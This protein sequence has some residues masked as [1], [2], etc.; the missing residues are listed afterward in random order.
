MDAR[1]TVLYQHVPSAMYLCMA[2]YC[3]DRIRIHIICPQCMQQLASMIAA[4]TRHKP[5]SM[6]SNFPSFVLF[7]VSQRVLLTCKGMY[8]PPCAWNAT[9]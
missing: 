5:F 1:S 4:S 7:G 6:L 3:Y 8:Y 2:H 9:A